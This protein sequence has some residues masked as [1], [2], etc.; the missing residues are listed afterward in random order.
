MAT[1]EY[2]LTFYADTDTLFRAYITAFNNALTALGLVKT[3]QTGEINLSTVLVP[4]ALNQDRGFQI[5]RFNDSLQ[6]TNPVFI[7]FTYGSIQAV[8]S[9]F[10]V[11]QAYY[12]VRIKIQVATANDGAGTLQ[13]K[14]SQERIMSY[15]SDNLS[16]SPTFAATA[17][18]HLLSGSTSRLMFYRG[19]NSSQVENWAYGGSQG[20]NICTRLHSF[21]SIE[22]SK[23]NN[24]DDTGEG[25]MI[26]S[27]VNAVET[28]NATNTPYF[29]EFIPY[30]RPLSVRKHL[31]YFPCFYVGDQNYLST[32]NYNTL[33][34]MPFYP[35][36]GGIMKNP[37]I[38]QLGYFNADFTY[39]EQATPILHYGVERLYRP[40][41]ADLTRLP[42]GYINTMQAASR[43]MVL[44]E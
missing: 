23:D 30:S 44:W 7:K 2:D 32:L 37:A 25:I 43:M 24:G 1:Q 4:S 40:I 27:Q 33:A 38:N 22:R 15:Y 11:G 42:F 31:F 19:A 8:A 5:W 21:F 26:F 35:F 28:A 34:T 9:A 20:G 3:T 14:I 6:A 41:I 10:S 16:N 18:K 17:N 39:G 13:G 36:E 12:I 29:H